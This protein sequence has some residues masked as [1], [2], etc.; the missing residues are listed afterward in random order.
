[1]AKETNPTIIMEAVREYVTENGSS[2][3]IWLSVTEIC[4]LIATIYS[5]AGVTKAVGQDY[6]NRVS[7]IASDRRISIIADGVMSFFQADNPMVEGN[8]LAEDIA[9]IGLVLDAA[10]CRQQDNAEFYNITE[11]Y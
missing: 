11:R 4:N 9:E 2:L 10:V 3:D 5:S 6:A 7:V 8:D 1:M